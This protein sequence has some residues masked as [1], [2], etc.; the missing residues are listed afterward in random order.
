[1][2]LLAIIII[3]ELFHKYPEK[4]LSEISFFNSLNAPTMSEKVMLADTKS[5]L[6]N[7]ILVKLDRAAMYYGLE[8]RSPFLMIG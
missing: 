3:L 7:N 2:Q 4:E 1:M 8:T 6:P 5:Y